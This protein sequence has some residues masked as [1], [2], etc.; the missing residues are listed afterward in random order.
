LRVKAG[1]TDDFE[2]LE[3]TVT[4]AESEP[5]KLPEKD[6]EFLGWDNEQQPQSKPDKRELV[7]RMSTGFIFGIVG[8]SLGV[9]SFLF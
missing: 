4:F 5:D 7:Y 9:M 1:F 3:V 8:I 2:I 6:E